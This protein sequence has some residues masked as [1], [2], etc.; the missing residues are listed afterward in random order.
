[1]VIIHPGVAIVGMDVTKP[2]DVAIIG[3]E[4]TKPTGVN[5]CLHVMDL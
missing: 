4:V 3:M 5:L 2:P 1:M